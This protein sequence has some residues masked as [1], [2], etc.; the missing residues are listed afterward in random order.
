MIQAMS[1]QTEV[2]KVEVSWQVQGTAG[3]QYDWSKERM[4]QG[5]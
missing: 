4:N 5:D 1:S 3:G 2:F